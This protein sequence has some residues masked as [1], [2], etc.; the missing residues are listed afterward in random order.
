MKYYLDNILLQDEPEGDIT[1]TIKRDAELGGYLITNDAK[2]NFWGDGYDYIQGRMAA[3]F[4]GEIEIKI[5]DECNGQP[6]QI[7]IGKIFLLEITRSSN[8]KINTPL[9]DNNY[10]ARISKNKSIKTF[11][12]STRSKNG[13]TIEAAKENFMTMFTPSTGVA[14]PGTRK[15]WR[16]FDVFKNLVSFLSDGEM[17]FNS[18]YLGLGGEFE[19]LSIT[20]G[21]ELFQ[22]GSGAA[23]QISF[24]DFYA[25][26][27]KKLHTVIFINLTGTLPELRIES[28][29]V[30]YTTNIIKKLEAVGEVTF[31]V[32]ASKLIAKVIVGSS[33]T[34]TATNLSFEGENKYY[35]YKTEEYTTLGQCN[36]DSTL[37]L[38]SRYI[39]DTNTIEDCLIFQNNTFSEDICFIDCANV[40]V[41]G[42]DYVSDAIADSPFSTTPPSFYNRR[43]M[44]DRVLERWSNA[45]PNSI[46]S[47]SGTVNNL[48][49]AAYTLG[50]ITTTVGA[51][52]EPF[53]F[54]DDYNFPLFDG[55][56][57]VNNYGNGTAQGSQISAANSRYTCPED[58]NYTFFSQYFIQHTPIDLTTPGNFSVTFRRYNSLNVLQDQDGQ[59][60]SVPV[61]AIQNI[62][63]TSKVFACDQNDYVQ[64]LII[65]GCPVSSILT[66]F[67]VGSTPL[68]SCI[69]APNSGG[70]ISTN[71]NQT[72]IPLIKADFEYYI[73]NHDFYDIQNDLFGKIQFTFNVKDAVKVQEGWID[74]I[75]YNH[76]T[77]ETK[78]TLRGPQTL[79][80]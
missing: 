16:V 59:N 26:V 57:I 52:V 24:S 74:I 9:Q 65:Y 36:M 72:N 5:N 20:T 78:I 8:C 29:A 67:S 1:T 40:V 11:I 75:K 13:A 2:L 80:Q 23:P 37:D 3:G 61:G 15:G 77:S 44:N 33:Q 18:T 25:E 31:K 48:F 43:L 60:F 49:S 38:V 71:N 68:F 51:I 12:D 66:I 32:D 50:T 19:G 47:F 56:G 34:M 14:L 55:N 70:V 21:Q 39:T 6:V 17:T 42:S 10:Y 69:S 73:P 30:T 35:T 63:I 53:Q 27:N 54:N 41:S 58:G 45:L 64:I 7:F 79:I 46:V 76:N 62:Q 4:C 22:A 28:D